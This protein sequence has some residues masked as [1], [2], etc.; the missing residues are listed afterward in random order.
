MIIVSGFKKQGK[1]L[2]DGCSDEKITSLASA[3]HKYQFNSSKIG[4]PLNQL[5]QM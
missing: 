5:E 2:F 1:Y 3:L 4:W